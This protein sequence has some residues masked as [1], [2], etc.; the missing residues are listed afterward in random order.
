MQTNPEI[1][2]RTALTAGL[3]GL[4]ALTL[5]ACGDGGGGSS[6]GSSGSSD[7]PSSG[8]K[9]MA[10]DGVKVNDSASAKVSGENVLVFRTGADSAVCFSATCTHMGCTVNPD[11]IKFVCPCHGSE[12][13]AKTGKVLSGPAP[14][15]LPQIPVTV[16]GGEIVTAED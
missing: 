9:V 13:D 7:A 5:A 1:A 10:L 11:G 6:S 2:R 16:T 15:P 14:R 4:G 12:Y 3:A 8:E